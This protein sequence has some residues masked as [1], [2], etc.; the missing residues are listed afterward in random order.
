MDIGIY[1]HWPFCLSKCPYCDFNS[2]ARRS[3]DEKVFLKTYTSELAFFRSELLGKGVDVDSL[4][5]RSIFFGGGTPSLIS[6]KGV[7][8]IL[9]AISQFFPFEWNHCEISMEMNPGTVCTK[10]L[11]GYARAGVNRAS[12]GGQSLCDSTLRFLGRCHTVSQFRKAIAEARRIFPAVSADFIYGHSGH[13]SLHLWENEL[14]EIIGLELDH[15]SLYQLTYAPGTPFFRLRKKG[16]LIP[17]SDDQEAELLLMT[18]E[19]MKRAGVPP[20]EI[21]NYARS[22]SVQCVHNKLYWRYGAYV[23]LGPGAHGRLHF[24]HEHVLASANVRSPDAWIEKVR[25]CGSAARCTRLSKRQIAW[26]RL[27]LGLR[28][29]EGIEVAPFVW[30]ENFMAEVERLVEQRFLWH[31]ASSIGVPENRKLMLDLVVQKLAHSM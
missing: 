10:R 27:A 29:E 17:I 20:Y 28:L 30:S 18:R 22:P 1:I 9:K 6:P 25:C 15:L 24:P 19:R 3:W 21:S 11:E 2:Y 8:N 26:E 14:E 31:K 23:G 7:G 4:C 5:I 16:G 12:I 13:A